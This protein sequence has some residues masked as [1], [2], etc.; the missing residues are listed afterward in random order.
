MIIMQYC[1]YGSVHDYAKRL[2]AEAEKQGVA[3]THPMANVRLSPSQLR[4]P[5]CTRAVL[6]PEARKHA[7]THQ[8]LFCPVAD[9]LCSGL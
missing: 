8:R 4:V 7:S 3:P 6:I 2:R 5:A 9:L 1:D